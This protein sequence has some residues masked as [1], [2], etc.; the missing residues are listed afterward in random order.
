MKYQLMRDTFGG[1]ETLKKYVERFVEETD[2]S[3]DYRLRNLTMQ[4]YLRRTIK[5]AIGLIFRKDVQ[6][7]FAGNSNNI[8]PDTIFT[9]QNNSILRELTKELLLLG[10]SYLVTDNDTNEVYQYIVPTDTV[11]E[12]FE[13]NNEV[14]L[15]TYVTNI[16]E[17]DD[18]VPVVR[19]YRYR[20]KLKDGL[21]IVEIEIDNELFEI[22]ETGLNYIPV[23]KFSIG[24]NTLLSQSEG[25]TL[26]SQSGSNI[27]L[28]DL[29]KLNIEWVNRRS[30]LSRYL[31]IAACPVPTFYG[32]EGQTKIVVGVDK[33]LS[34]T[35][36]D[37]GGFEWVEMSGSST[38]LLQNDLR[39]LENAMMDTA[40]SLVSKRDVAKNAVQISAEIAEDESFLTTVSKVLEDGFN[41][42][43][44][45][46]CDMLNIEQIIAIVNKDFTSTIISLDEINVLIELLNSGTIN[47]EQMMEMLVSGEFIPQSVANTTDQ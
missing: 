13:Q 27:P 2:E 35:D 46:Y 16:E 22:K 26:L 8:E 15:F 38:E 30:E 4:N 31:R 42:S 41:K 39:Q 33:A 36:K 1:S 32:V 10:S 6:Y 23:V 17:L 40:I 25:N 5:N 19:E 11:E 24:G 47:Q 14:L 45:F 20:W 44:I 12:Y 37:T 34:F 7:N 43:L 28:L 18:W 3:F 29:A 21:A 9:E